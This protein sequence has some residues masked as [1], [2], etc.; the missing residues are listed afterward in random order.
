MRTAHEVSRALRRAANTAH[1]HHALGLHAH[2]IHG[3]DDAL[4]D[5]VVT[6]PCAKRG[7]TPAIFKYWKPDVIDLGAW[8]RR[9]RSSLG[10][11]IYRPSLVANSS[12]I[13]RASMGSPL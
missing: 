2:L 5:C 9:R 12:V 10:C 13:V 7:L 11:H 6:A 4:R 8:S 3:I 1:L